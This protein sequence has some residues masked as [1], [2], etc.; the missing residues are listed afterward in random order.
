MKVRWS[1]PV[2]AGT[3]VGAL[4]VWIGDTLS[5]ETPLFTAESVGVGALHQR[6]HRCGR[7][8]AG[9][10]AA[11]EFRD[12]DSVPWTSRRLRSMADG[13]YSTIFQYESLRITLPSRNV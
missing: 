3:P 8:V 11:V 12:V 7:G 1:A 13:V 5:Q 6:A 2:E 4:K 10:L 9:R